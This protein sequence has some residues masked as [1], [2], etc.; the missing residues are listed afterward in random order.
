MR[1]HFP[2]QHTARCRRGKVI[3][4]RTHIWHQCSVIISGDI[5]TTKYDYDC[6][7]RYI[8][9]LCWLSGIDNDTN[10]APFQSTLAIWFWRIIV[11]RPRMLS[12]QFVALYKYCKLKINLKTIDSYASRWIVNKVDPNYDAYRRQKWS[13]GSCIGHKYVCVNEVGCRIVALKSWYLYFCPILRSTGDQ[14]RFGD[15][16]WN[17]ATESPRLVHSS[18]PMTRPVDEHTDRTYIHEAS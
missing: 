8:A 6:D 17:G 13:I 4:D 5:L 1:N 16:E 3:I 11:K 10:P 2:C 15:G 18:R 14:V 12:A 9:P 7:L